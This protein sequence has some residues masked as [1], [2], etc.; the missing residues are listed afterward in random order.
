[1][2]DLFVEDGTDSTRAQQLSP[3]AAHEIRDAI[4]GRHVCPFCGA[5]R[6]QNDGVCSRC[7]MDNTSASRQAT[8][9]RIRALV[10]LSKP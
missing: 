3:D 4:A 6:E 5:V 10:R 8:K 2:R 9:A 7:T 1:M